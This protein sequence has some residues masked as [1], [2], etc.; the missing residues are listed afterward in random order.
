MEFAEVRPYQPGDDV[1][2]IDWNVTAR[3]G[4]PYVKR[5][6]E[7]RELTVMLLVDASASTRFGSVRQ[8]K[9]ELAAELA[10]LLAFSAITNNDK[11]GLVLFTDRVELSL[12]P[13]KGTRHVLR[14]IREVL[15]IQ[16][17][18]ARHRHRAPR[19]STSSASTKRRSVV[20]VVSDFLDP[21]LRATR[22]RIAAR[23]HDVIAVVLDDPREAELPPSASSSSR[24]RRPA[25][26]TSS[27]PATARVR[28]A[29]AREAAARAHGTRPRAPRR[30]RRR[31]RRRHRPPVRRGAAAL[32]PH[33]GAPA[34]SA[35]VAHSRSRRWLLVGP[36]S[37]RRAWRQPVATPRRRLAAPPRRDAVRR[38]RDRRASPVAVTRKAEPDTVTIGT[39]FRY[40]VEVIA[41]PG[42]A[43]GRWR[44]RPS[45]SA[46]FDIVDFGD[47]PTRH[48]RR[49]DGHHALV[50][51]RRLRGR[52]TS[53]SHRRR[54][55]TA[56]RAR[57]ARPRRP[58]RRDRRH[59][60]E[61]ARA[62]PAT[63]TDIR[64]I[65]PPE[66]AAGRLATVLRRRRRASRC[67]S[68][69]RAR[70]SYRVLRRR[71]RA[72][73]R[74]AAAPAARDRARRRSSGCARAR[75][76]EQRRLQGVLL[77]A[78]GHRARATS[79]GASACARRR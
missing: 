56:R 75:L 49:Q 50:H 48:A 78:L 23:R 59:D 62:R 42:V 18:R 6:A 32:L 70:S 33:A 34:M 60:R 31:G 79:S 10:A 69:A 37:G 52:A 71:S 58:A 22:S 29:F 43:G 3:T 5:Y 19:S 45:A 1:R 73:P 47:A 61:R 11:V 38:R 28:E 39:R 21:R 9:S 46:S 20:F 13:R 30:R 25:S 57:R 55:A 54:S 15:S 76:I 40:T 14:V 27:T 53:S 44:S 2:T 7:E 35:L 51:A 4:E 77:G 64:D 26:A 74:G 36:P 8:L 24:R 65:K 66:R 67:S 63:P 68:L 17:A 16:P 12:P 41:P 72:A